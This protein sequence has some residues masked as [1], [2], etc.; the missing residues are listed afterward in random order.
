MFAQLP[1]DVTTSLETLIPAKYVSYITAALVLL[2]FIGRA[3]TAIRNEGGF[4]SIFRSVFMGSSTTTTAAPNNTVSAAAPAGIPSSIPKSSVALLL[5]FLGAS[6]W[7]GCSTIDPA[8][9][10][11][12]KPAPFLVFTNGSAYL[13]GHAVSSNEIYTVTELGAAE[14]AKL[15]IADQPGA[16]N[17]LADAQA[18]IQS[19]ANSGAYNQALLSNS[20]SSISAKI[21]TD[22]PVVTGLIQTALSLAGVYVNPLVSSNTNS[23]PFIQAAL[24]G[25]GDGL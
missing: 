20:L 21:P 8:L 16:S 4:S 10:G 9:P 2:T 18:A 11:Q 14:G 7:C 3:V 12:S 15:L 19:I 13:L 22:G 17:Y 6:L 24:H 1:A 25:L 23:A 5:C